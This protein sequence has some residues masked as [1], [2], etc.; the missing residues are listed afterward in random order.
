MIT[1]AYS[2]RKYDKTYERHV[3][4]TCGIKN[5]EILY[6]ENQNQ[7]SLATLYNK[8]LDIAQNDIIIFIHDD[9]EFH[10]K[11]WGRK[12]L[13]NFKDDYG[14]V[15]VAGTTDIVRHPQDPHN[16]SWWNM[17]NRSV[18]AVKHT[19][20]KKTWESRYSNKFNK[21]IDVCAV[22]GL[23]MAINRTKIKERFDERFAG[24]HWYDI[25]FCLLNYHQGVKI[26]VT[27]DIELLHK[28][29]GE[30]N[31]QW[32]ENMELFNKLYDDKIPTN[33]PGKIFYD[34]KPIK[35]FFGNN[36]LTSVIILTKN[37]IDLVKDCVNS[38]IKH[39]YQTP[40]EIIIGDTGS[41]EESKEE[42]FAFQKSLR[43]TE[44]F[45]GLRVIEYEY[46][47]FAKIN[48]H[49]V[50][51]HLNEKTDY[52][53]FCNNDIKL[54]NDCLDRCHKVFHIQPKV[55][56]VGIRLHYADNSIQHNSI[57][58]AINT[59]TNSLHL[60]HENLKSFYSYNDNI[61]ETVGNTGAFLM[62]RKSEF[63]KF[64]FNESYI[65]CFEDVEL[66]LQFI[67]NGLIN[68]HVGNAVAYHYESQ[69]RNLDENKI[70]KVNQDYLK[71][72]LPFVNQN[73]K[74]LEKYFKYFSNG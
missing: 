24:F 72:I 14:I 30:V 71:N 68:I 70:A 18:G 65:E 10:T 26:G 1:I 50:K 59:K 66:N 12:I 36:S 23:F 29:I 55:G 34:E 17:K 7:Y 8:V 74:S 53:L 37:K 43:K 67:L 69:T 44:I 5:V 48:N 20:G 32:K 28:S 61:F 64:Y 54:L 6:F 25:P 51:N 40:F 21:P 63:N 62:C 56:S 60:G 46:Y 16:T 73:K 38:L 57:F 15:G 3:K 4:E 19:N 39:T 47:N 27:F 2:T 41:S 33:H 58:C 31:N 45:Q 13:D 11:S 49:I 22:D 42:L 9:L 35:L 52:I